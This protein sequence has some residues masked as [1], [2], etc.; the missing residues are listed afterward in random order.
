MLQLWIASIALV[1]AAALTTTQQPG[2]IGP[3]AG[4]Q[5]GPPQGT[6][7]VTPI[8]GGQPASR[9]KPSDAEIQARLTDSL[10]IMINRIA[11]LRRISNTPA[12]VGT[13]PPAPAPTIEAIRDTIGE[14][15]REVQRRAVSLELTLAGETAEKLCNSSAR[16]IPRHGFSAAPELKMA[17]P[18]PNTPA[19]SPSPGATASGATLPAFDATKAADVIFRV[20]G[21]AITRGELESMVSAMAR[22][23]PEIPKETHAQ[24]ALNGAIVPLALRRAKM[25][26]SSD[27]IIARAKTARDEIVAGKKT[28]EAMAQEISEDPATK[29]FGGL[30]DG[31]RPDSLTPFERTA[32]ADLKPGEISQPFMTGS[33]VELLQLIEANVN[34]MKPSESTFKLRRIMI[35]LNQ[36]GDLASLVKASRADVLDER[37]ESFL[38][39]QLERNVVAPKK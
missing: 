12:P 13:N 21:V 38:P 29:K 14:I 32:L 26:N 4:P 28:F 15:T 17:Q 20:N 2:T 10:G 36:P 18:T 34:E 30:L 7:G 6:P 5:V 37:Y 3:P 16:V 35:S 8:P 22:W 33:A 1:S 11:A 9:P 39:A 23:S 24:R 19:G 25:G 31:W 27:P